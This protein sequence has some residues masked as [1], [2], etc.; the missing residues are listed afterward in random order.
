M[1]LQLLNELAERNIPGT[2][3]ESK[4]FM[5][6]GNAHT[7]DKR[8]LAEITYV[9]LMSLFVLYQNSHTRKDASDYARKTMSWDPSGNFARHRIQ[10]TDLYIALQ[11]LH[12][13]EHSQIAGQLKPT[14]ELTKVQDS[15][16]RIA[17]TTQPIRR[18][19]WDIEQYGLQ[20]EPPRFF[21]NLETQLFI[22]DSTLRSIRRQVT[23]WATLTKSEKI[24]VISRLTLWL[25]RHSK[26]FDIIPLMNKL[27][28]ARQIDV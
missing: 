7:I 1:D 13:Y 19:L 25:K 23:S 20:F 11:A 10:A 22:T 6:P 3:M 5:N 21:Y 4:F 26:Q 8:D 28:D 27:L 2:Y 15:Q 18:F 12:N 14:T 17:K 24:Y 9:T 16:M